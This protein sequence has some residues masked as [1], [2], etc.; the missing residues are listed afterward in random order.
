MDV[1]L[2]C[3][4]N[5]ALRGGVAG[6]FAGCFGLAFGLLLAQ[7]GGGDVYILIQAGGRVI[8]QQ[9]GGAI[10]FQPAAQAQLLLLDAGVDGSAYAH[11]PVGPGEHL[12]VVKLQLHVHLQASGI[13]VR[14]FGR[15]VNDEPPAA[16]VPAALRG[17]GAVAALAQDAGLAAATALQGELFNV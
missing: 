3:G 11:L 8:G 10:D 1:G 6:C 9:Q 5:G 14:V 15:G 12:Q 7:R 2:E 4:P 17:G 13:A 16:Q